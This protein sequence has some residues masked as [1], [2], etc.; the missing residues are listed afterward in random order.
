MA[1][2]ATNGESHANHPSKIE[3]RMYI[4]GELVP[5]ISGK[6]FDIYNPATEKLSASIFEA[7]SSDVDAAVKAAKAAFPAWSDLAADARA[8]YL[9]KLA[10]A[11]EKAVPELSYLDAIS[12]GKP[13]RSDSTGFAPT[14]LR[15]FAGRAT[16]IQGDTSL[17]TPGMVNMTF[18]QPY[19]VCGAIIPWNGPIVMLAFKV[20]PALIA[21]NTLVL[22]SSEKAPLSVAVIGRLCKEIGLPAGVLNILSGYGRPCGEAIAKHMQIRKV[23]FTGSA[24]TGRAVKKAAADS[25]LK[26]VT[27]EL[28]GKSPLIIFDDADLEAAVPTATASILMNSGQVCV[29]SS[30]VY[31]HEAVSEKFVEMMKK[32]MS[33]MGRN[34][35]LDPTEEGNARGPQADKLQ[36]VS[37]LDCSLKIVA[38]CSVRSALCRS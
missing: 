34:T 8:A 31:V 9:Y 2:S 17:N 1:P 14:V 25:N 29:A 5:S 30:R 18:R 12:M 10:D 20:G 13:V 7:D 35:S 22:K 28:G 3:D 37:R 21:G 19:G 11:I 33:E 4:N 16:A 27:L 15:Y 6:K 26:N 32:S 23:A 36:F 24:A 38:D